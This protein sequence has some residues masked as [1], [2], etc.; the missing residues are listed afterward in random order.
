ML[1]QSKENRQA[2]DIHEISM[3]LAK[4]HDELSGIN[5]QLKAIIGMWGGVHIYPELREKKYKEAEENLV[6]R[7]V[8][9]EKFDNPDELS[10][11]V[12]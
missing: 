10:E 3:T 1:T 2:N 11:Y 7:D 5:A 4:V 12:G 9:Q 6:I 8:V